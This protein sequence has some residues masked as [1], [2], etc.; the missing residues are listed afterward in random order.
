MDWF[1]HFS[2]VYRKMPH[3]SKS[4]FLMVLRSECVK[5]GDSISDYPVNLFHARLGC[6]EARARVKRRRRFRNG[7]L[8][9]R[10]FR[11]LGLRR[12]N[13][14]QTIKAVRSPLNDKVPF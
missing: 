10:T 1:A 7:A 14:E 12:L 11:W 3:H 2:E 13:H 9:G 5:A 6:E 8:L 4:H